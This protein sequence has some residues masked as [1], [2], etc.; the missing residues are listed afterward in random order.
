MRVAQC[1]LRAPKKKGRTVDDTS[2]FRIRLRVRIA[3]GLTTEATS[4]SLTV[5][6]SVVTIKSQNKD[7]PLSK[8]RW[9]VLSARGLSTEEQA[10]RF[11]I[12]SRSIVQLAALSARLGVDAGEDKSTSWVSEDFARKIGLIEEDERIAS[13]VHGLTILLDDD[14]TRFPVINVQATATA[15]GKSSIGRP[16]CA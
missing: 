7:E 15:E 13:N 14:K 10:R 6:N 1:A 5:S 8:A 16:V 4:L 11:G 2:G 12:R 3:K 9:I